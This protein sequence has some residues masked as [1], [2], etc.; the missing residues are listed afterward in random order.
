MNMIA[1][2][3]VICLLWFL[4]QAYC[5]FAREIFKFK[6]AYFEHQ[7][8]K[9]NWDFFNKREFMSGY[10]SSERLKIYIS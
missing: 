10:V 2:K 8:W 4:M 3:F 7:T 1:M 9:R 5:Y 6:L